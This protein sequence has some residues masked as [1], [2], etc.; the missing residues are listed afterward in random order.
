VTGAIVAFGAV[1]WIGVGAQVAMATNQLQVETLF[2]TVDSCPCLN[3]TVSDTLKDSAMAFQLT[4]EA[5]N[6]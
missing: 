3:Q 5:S 6:K 1:M 4:Q 2:L